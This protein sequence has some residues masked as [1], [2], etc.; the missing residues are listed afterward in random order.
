MCST[1]LTT[2][3]RLHRPF[4]PLRLLELRQRPGH[5]S[6]LSSL[7]RLGTLCR[8]LLCSL[9]RLG[10]LCRLGS[11]SLQL[12]GCGSSWMPCEPR[13]RAQARSLHSRLHS[14][15]RSEQGPD[16]Q[17]SMCRLLRRRWCDWVPRVTSKA[18]PQGLRSRRSCLHCLRR[19][20]RRW[21]MHRHM[22][23]RRHGC[24]RTRRCGRRCRHRSRHR[25]RRWC[26]CCRSCERPRLDPHGLCEEHCTR[27]DVRALR[28]SACRRHAGLGSMRRRLCSTM[29]CEGQPGRGLCGMRHLRRC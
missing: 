9:S 7:C 25:Q 5:W 16:L 20:H 14:T 28:G 26:R 19:W 22:R 1:P 21:C 18:P 23:S 17:A 8:P 10:S 11:T 15:R 6:Q 29:G 2:S 3:L 13:R 24:W 12:G 27:P 4:G